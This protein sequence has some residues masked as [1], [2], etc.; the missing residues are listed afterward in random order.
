MLISAVETAFLAYCESDFCYFQSQ[1][2]ADTQHS[3]F[4]TSKLSHFG[5]EFATW[6]LPEKSWS[7]HASGI[8]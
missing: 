3:D 7:E 4:S 5:Q 8:F 1:P 6:C 2:Q